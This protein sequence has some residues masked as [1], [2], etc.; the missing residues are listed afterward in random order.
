MQIRA[1][2]RFNEFADADSMRAAALAFI[3]ERL[4]G[5]V[6]ARG[7]ALFLVSGGSTPLPLYKELAKAPLDWAK[8]EIALVDERWVAP[9]HQAS[10]ERAIRASLLAGEAARARFVAMKT[11]HP[12]PE[13]AVPT[14]DRVLRMLSWPADVV[15]LGMGSDG[16]TASWFPNARGLDAAIDLE[17]DAKCAA[18]TARESAVTGAFTQRMTLTAPPVLSAGAMLL[19]MTGEDK[20]RTFARARASGPVDDMPVRTLFLGDPDRLFC[21]WSP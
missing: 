1:G 14:L 9:D 16:H 6:A 8:V 5:A 11:D 4:S 18:V 19:L 15:V 7:K 10:N 12:A 2:T 13:E 17:T 20:K 21:C 3:V